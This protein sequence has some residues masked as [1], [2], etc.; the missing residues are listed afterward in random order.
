MSEQVARELGSIQ[1]T[2]DHIKATQDAHTAKLNRIDDRVRK[3]ETKSAL[4]GAVTGG[5]VAIA[6]AFIKDTLKT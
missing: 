2:L 6:V 4:N 3:V 1:A 5:I